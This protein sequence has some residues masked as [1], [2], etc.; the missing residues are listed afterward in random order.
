MNNRN[1]FMQELKI[2]EQKGEEEIRKEVENKFK[3]LNKNTSKEY[4][5]LLETEKMIEHGTGTE[6]IGKILEEFYNSQLSENLDSAIGNKSKK[7][8][9]IL[10]E[11][12]DEYTSTLGEL[13]KPEE[14]KER[15][16][17]ILDRMKNL[18]GAIEEYTKTNKNE[19]GNS[20]IEMIKDFYNYIK[21]LKDQIEIFKG[22]EPTI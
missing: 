21:A 10:K 4:K 12:N 19:K 14:S 5:I 18:L 16:F 6:E 1:N 17:A 8:E 15:F 9:L 20:E 13:K 3:K 7:L 22:Q 2:S 11:S